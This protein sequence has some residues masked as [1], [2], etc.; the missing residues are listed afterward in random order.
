MKKLIHLLA[1]PLAAL[2][3]AQPVAAAPFRLILTHLEPPLVPNSVMD[4]ALEKGYFEAEGV[5]V[6]LHDVPVCVRERLRK[7]HVRRFRSTCYVS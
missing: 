5:D 4:L 3:F 2:M 1:P 6:E 7:A